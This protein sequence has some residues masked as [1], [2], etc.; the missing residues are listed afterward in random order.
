[1]FLSILY[2]VIA[3]PPSSAGASHETSIEGP[4]AALPLT[5][6]GSSGTVAPPPPACVVALA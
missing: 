2:P 4:A 1:M 5:L 3:E 6:V